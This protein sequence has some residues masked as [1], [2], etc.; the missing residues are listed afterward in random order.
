M[1]DLRRIRDISDSGRGLRPD[2]AGNGPYLDVVVT[3]D[4]A[5]AR[6]CLFALN[7]DLESEREL[8]LK[9][10]DPVP[11]RVLDCKTLTGSDLKAANTFERPMIVA[12]QDLDARG[13]PRR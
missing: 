13:P 6:A 8:V 2:F 4:T 1:L 7:R 5:N 9:W 11:T 3:L 10:Q 12:P